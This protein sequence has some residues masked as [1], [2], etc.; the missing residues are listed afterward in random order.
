M[1]AEVPI[2]TGVF[3]VSLVVS[4]ALIPIKLMLIAKIKVMATNFMNTEFLFTFFVSL[5]VSMIAFACFI[6]L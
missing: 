5:R 6:C 3:L 1:R 2:R 4:I